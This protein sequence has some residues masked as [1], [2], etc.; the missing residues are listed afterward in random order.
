MIGFI[1]GLAGGVLELFLLSRMIGSV[2]GGAV[3]KTA[4]L[5]LLKLLALAASFAAVILIK[6]G[7]LIWCAVGMTGVLI[8]GSVL[9]FLRKNSRPK[10][11]NGTDE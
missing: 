8:G 2:T 9:L 11:G 6:R 1:F 4:L 10:G 3:G 7:E 5:L